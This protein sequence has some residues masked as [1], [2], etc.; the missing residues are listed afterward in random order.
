MQDVQWNNRILTKLLFFAV[1]LGLDVRRPHFFK[2]PA[3][4]IAGWPLH[5]A[6]RGLLSCVNIPRAGNHRATP[7]T[8]AQNRSQDTPLP[9]ETLPHQRALVAE[10]GGG[11]GKF[12]DVCQLGLG[13]VTDFFF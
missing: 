1:D 8:R 12:T 13:P 11:S 9:D 7:D 6:I 3:T 5:E 10:G 2:D 4:A